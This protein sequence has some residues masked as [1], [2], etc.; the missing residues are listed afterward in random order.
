M[1][2]RAFQLGSLPGTTSRSIGF[3]L[4]L[5]ALAELW[6]DVIEIADF[7]VFLRL[8]PSLHDSSSH[9]SRRRRS[10]IFK[11]FALRMLASFISQYPGLSLAFEFMFLYC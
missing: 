5:N 6:G 2:S 11:D 7:Q 9:N 1:D 4:P 10:G 3:K 8:N